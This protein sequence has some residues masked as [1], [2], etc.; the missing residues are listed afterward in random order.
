LP[1]I[2]KQSI[3]RIFWIE[4]RVVVFIVLK[5]FVKVKDFTKL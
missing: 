1:S 2:K 4:R 3:T 5:N